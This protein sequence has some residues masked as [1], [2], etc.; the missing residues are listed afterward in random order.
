MHTFVFRLVGKLSN[1]TVDGHHWLPKRIALTLGAY[2]QFRIRGL[3]CCGR[4][5]PFD[6]AQGRL[7]TRCLERLRTNVASES[8]PV[9][10]KNAMNGEATHPS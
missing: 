9:R 1:C 6:F 7:S 8:K 3:G 2:L 5:F 4:R 10:G